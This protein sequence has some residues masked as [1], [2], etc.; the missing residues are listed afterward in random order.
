M[1]FVFLSFPAIRLGVSSLSHLNQDLGVLDA[2]LGESLVHVVKQ[3]LA[4]EHELF[5]ISVML[6]MRGQ[7]QT[8]P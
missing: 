8:Y 1:G 5:W 4:N 3:L 6:A 2:D 7:N